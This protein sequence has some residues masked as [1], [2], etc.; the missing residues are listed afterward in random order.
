M[1]MSRCN[2]AGCDFRW[3]SEIGELGSFGQLWG[4]WWGIR[5][6]RR[7]GCS[8]TY[9]AN[10]SE[11]NRACTLPVSTPITRLVCATRRTF[12]RR[13]RTITVFTF[14]M[15]VAPFHRWW[16]QKA[17]SIS[18]TSK[19]IYWIFVVECFSLDLMLMRSVWLQLTTSS[20][21]KKVVS[22]LYLYFILF[23]ENMKQNNWTNCR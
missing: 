20:T 21:I 4:Q 3:R 19:F 1:R 7:T 13:M 16:W 9:R 12:S 23:F 22:H 15:V 11:L 18:L 17:L 10:S 5:E 2:V 8:K 14:R 6:R